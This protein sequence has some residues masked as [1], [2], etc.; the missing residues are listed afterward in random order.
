[1]KR[2]CRVIPVHFHSYPILSRASQEKVRELAAVLTRYQQFTR[3]YM[4]AFGEIQQQVMLAV[5]PPL[6][7]VIYRRLML[8]IAQGDCRDG[9]RGRAR[10]GRGD[11]PGRVADAR[12]HGDD[13]IGGD[14]AGVPAAHR[15]GQGRDHGRGAAARHISD[16]DYRRSGLLPAVHAEASGDQGEARRT[17]RPRNAGCRSTNLCARPSRRPS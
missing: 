6:R 5:P 4:V 9:A 8:R 12:E 3:L 1:M 15:H 16:L 2:G 11:R 13:R 7:V 17:S 10:D 14:A